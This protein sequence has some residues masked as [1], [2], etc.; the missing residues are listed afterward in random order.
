MRPMLEVKSF[1]DQVQATNGSANNSQ[2]FRVIQLRWPAA[3]ALIQAES[4]MSVSVQTSVM[5]IPEW[6]D[7]G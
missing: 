7:Y 2:V 6:G 1:G 5:C 4:K 3:G